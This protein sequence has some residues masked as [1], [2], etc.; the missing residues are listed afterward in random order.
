MI[1]KRPKSSGA[2]GAAKSSVARRTGDLQPERAGKRHMVHAEHGR[3]HTVG[4]EEEFIGYDGIFAPEDRS[5]AFGTVRYFSNA[6][7]PVDEP[8]EIGDESLLVRVRGDAVR[9]FQGLKAF[10]KMM[11]HEIAAAE[12]ADR[13]Q[14]ETNALRDAELAPETI[15]GI[16]ETSRKE[17]ER[18]SPKQRADLVKKYL[19]QP[20]EA[21]YPGTT[22]MAAEVGDPRDACKIALFLAGEGLMD[23]GTYRRVAQEAVYYIATADQHPP[24]VRIVVGPKHI[25]DFEQKIHPM[26]EQDSWTQAVT[27][28]AAHRRGL[29]FE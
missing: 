18:L 13:K 14:R 7:T 26:R 17:L 29:L 9:K 23:H 22:I 27:S 4:G 3:W 1:T 11:S 10:S 21:G 15:E 20:T 8:E 2:T 25:A 6:G 5:H 19:W 16:L 12:A 24:L 28:D